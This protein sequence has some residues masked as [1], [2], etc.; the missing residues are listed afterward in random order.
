[1]D[2]IIRDHTLTPLVKLVYNERK[3]DTEGLPVGTV[4]S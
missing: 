4:I 1:M 3:V 2:Q